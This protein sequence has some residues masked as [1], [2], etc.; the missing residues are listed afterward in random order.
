[1][2]RISSLFVQCISIGFLFLGSCGGD[3][4]DAT[5]GGCFQDVDCKGERICVRG[6]C[7]EPV[8][9]DDSTLPIDDDDTSTMDDDSTPI[10]PGLV[11]I[12]I[13]SGI[14]T[15]GCSPNDTKCLDNEQPPHTVNVSSFEMTETEITQAQYE[16]VMG[17]NP[18][19]FTSCG[20]DCPVETVD[21]NQA[22]AFC[23][24]VG[25]R[26]P[27]EAEWEYAARAGTTTKYYCG[28]DASCLE[29]IAWY[30]ASCT[31]FVKGKTPNYFG[32]YD[33]LGNVWE[34]VED[35]YH[36]DYTSAPSDGNVW[37]GGDCTY[38]VF[39]GGS[40]DYS[41]LDLLRASLRVRNYPVFGGGSFGFRCVV[42]AR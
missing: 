39:R 26:L 7:M 2:K 3:D 13:P 9:D 6:V 31:N 10:D 15:M 34:W 23:E 11:W 38:R 42:A 14:F 29:G 37:S 28:D 19:S 16:A 25:G 40:W 24:A 30:N 21:W 41:N 1:M 8:G 27:S 12:P 35:C 5:G 4:D 17:D 22:K 33:M 18:S 36:D 20:G 32:L